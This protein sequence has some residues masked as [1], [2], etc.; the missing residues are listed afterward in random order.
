MKHSKEIGAGCRPGLWSRM[1]K[2]KSCYLFLLPFFLLFTVFT[3]I[4]V[5]V[6]IGLSFTQY[7][8]L[9]APQFIG[10][11]NYIQMIFYDDLFPTVLSN[12]LTMAL[13]IGPIGYLMA[14]LV[15]WMINELSPALRTLLV[16]LFYA[17]SI[18]G[19][20]YLIWTLMFNSQFGVI[21]DFLFKLFKIRPAWL[22][23]PDLIMTVIIVVSVWSSIGYNIIILLAGLQ[24]VPTSYYEACEIDGGGP[25]TKFTKIT[26]PLVSPTVFSCS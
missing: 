17:P 1:K 13:F 22:T 26:L 5:V 14:L 19:N 15:A 20:A 6:A 10:A 3:V 8:V 9:E 21:N 16:I 4:P 18:S 24:N 23:S 7:N 11:Q 12:T 2:K 25:I